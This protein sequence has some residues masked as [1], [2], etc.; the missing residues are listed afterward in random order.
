MSLALRMSDAPASDASAVRT[1]TLLV[2]PAAGGFRM[3]TIQALAEAL[4]GRGLSVEIR[5]STAPGHL[6][7]LAATVETDVIAVAGGDGSVNE[8]VGALMARPAP[9]PTLAVVPQGTANVLAHEIALPSDP[10]RLAAVIAAG[11][12]R[13]LHI[14]LANGRPFFLMASAGFDAEIVHAVETGPRPR[15]KK[16]AFVHNALTRALG[17]G[18]PDLTIEADGRCHTARIAVVAKAK[19]YG[20]PFVLAREASAVAPGLVLVALK[21]DRPWALMRAAAALATGRLGPSANVIVEPVRR[22]RITSE[23]P[24][25]TQIDGEAMATTPLDVVAAERTLPVLVP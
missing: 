23:T 6:A 10:Q 22:V 4:R 8:V 11:R 17:R 12:R 20:G 19:H 9:V 18:G 7:E 3:K 16:L 2:N 15:F 21:S 24:V 25:A 14:G 13:D 5:M 1:V